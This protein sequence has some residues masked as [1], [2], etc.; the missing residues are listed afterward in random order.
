MGVGVTLTVLALFGTTS[1]ADLDGGS[2]PVESTTTVPEKPSTTTVP[3][4]T[5]TVPE[6]TTTVA[7]TTT[8][9]ETTTTTVPETT[10]TVAP[11]TT[12]PQTTTTVPDGPDTSATAS[13]D[14]SARRLVVTLTNRGDLPGRYVLA[15]TPDQGSAVT[16]T[17]DVPAR[18]TVTY[19]LAVTP[20]Q[21]G[22]LDIRSAVEFRSDIEVVLD[23]KRI[24]VVCEE[25]TT[26]TT[27]APTT[28]VPATAPSTTVGASVAPTSVVRVTETAL[29]H[30]GSDTNLPLAA[31]GITL[32]MLGLILL[33]L[34]TPAP[35]AE[36]R[37]R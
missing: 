13:V 25:P 15:F 28:T 30:T 22:R 7:P 1:G 35:A 37:R 29:A 21:R 26:T 2:G 6:T 12:V 17:A 3:E 18:S 10:T 14:C 31:V 5:T 36:R 20:P 9:P 23:G 19:A 32:F 8:V 34:R 27:A 33:E 16:T 4:T 24:E 11:T